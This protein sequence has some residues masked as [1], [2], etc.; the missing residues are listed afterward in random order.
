MVKNGTRTE[1]VIAALSDIGAPVLNGAVSTTL[2]V[3]L[4]A[5]SQS[6]I[7]RVLF[8]QFFGACVLGIL[9]GL[10]TLPVLLRWIGPASNANVLEPEEAKSANGSIS[11]TNQDTNDNEATAVT[12]P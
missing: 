7:F 6:Y 1:R 2:A 10:G 8:K 3:A 12:N 4:L 5:A 9:N 11:K